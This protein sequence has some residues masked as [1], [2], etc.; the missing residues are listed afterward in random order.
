MDGSKNHPVFKQKNTKPKTKKRK[1]D[2][3]YCTPCQEEDT[4]AYKTVITTEHRDPGCCLFSCLV[5]LQIIAFLPT[6][7]ISNIEILWE[8]ELMNSALSGNNHR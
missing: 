7:P 5:S 6:I 1:I 4:D 8:N 3:I 2:S